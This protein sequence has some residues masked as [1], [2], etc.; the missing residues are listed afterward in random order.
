MCSD[1]GTLSKQS[2]RNN[3]PDSST[4]VFALK[5]LIITVAA[6]DILIFVS[7]KISLDISCESS[8]RQADGSH[9]MP[10]LIFSKK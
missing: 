2:V 7:E 9:G 8:A 1:T 10:S 4:S 3:A 6:E 5:V